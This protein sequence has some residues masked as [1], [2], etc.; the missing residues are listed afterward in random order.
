MAFKFSLATLL[1]LKEIAEDREERLLGQI[2]NQIAQSKQTL[3]ELGNRRVGLIRRR[4]IALEQK[5]SAAELNV[6]HGQIRAIEDLEVS[7]HDQLVK[8]EALR[9]KQ[10]KLYEAAHQN[11]ELLSGMRDDQA[12]AHQ[13]ERTRQEQNVMDDNFSSRRLAR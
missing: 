5:T 3:I 8:L 4:E 12:E 9:L 13:R 2:M 7:G 1:R 6:F 10:M 11:R